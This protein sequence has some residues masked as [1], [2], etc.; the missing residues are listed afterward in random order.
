[1]ECLPQ[2]K[3]DSWGHYVS[4]SWVT[5]PDLFSILLSLRGLTHSRSAEKI[6]LREIANW[7]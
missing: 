4:V 2:A 3:Y 7:S 5:L 6:D 1:M